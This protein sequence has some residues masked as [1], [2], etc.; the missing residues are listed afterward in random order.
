MHWPSPEQPGAKYSVARGS[1]QGRLRAHNERV[2]LH[3]LRVKGPMARAELA[4][5]S[6][7]TP[8]TIGLIVKRLED[9]EL[10]CQHK[11]VRGRVGQPSIPIGL[12]PDGA[13][14]I[15]IKLGRR[16]TDILL[17]DFSARVLDRCTIEYPYPQVDK[18]PQAIHARLAQMQLTLGAR[19]GRV[20]GV[21]LAAPFMLGGWHR[22][23]GLSAHD[24]DH[25]NRI[26]LQAAIQAGSPW[27]VSFA[28]DT[29][30]ACIAELS[31]GAGQSI[32]N[33]LYLFIDTF[34]GGALVLNGQ[35]HSGIHGNAGAVASLPRATLS[36]TKISNP[37]DA[38]PGQLLQQASLWD[39]EQL[40][41]KQGLDMTAAY[42]ERAL[43]QPFS[44]LT[45]QWIESAADAL[46][47]CVISG[48]AITDV[49]H[50]VIDGSLAAPAL[51]KLLVAT[52]KA[53][54]QYSW[55]GLWRPALLKGQVGSDARALGGALLPLHEQFAPDHEIF[56]K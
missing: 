34:V 51:A 19:S 53:L 7:L 12:N 36:N 37:L 3:T 2:V 44:V 30:A 26:D 5:Q 20:A 23:L 25:W 11:P 52:E 8:Q 38:S 33:F 4:R 1:N 31:F 17:V 56:L 10:I 35:M 39:L 43:A 50:V 14:A 18:L 40:F 46:A 41:S 48:V 13:L 6:G 16:S 55:E 24:A 9:E 29:T 27:P 15:G 21:G 47:H 22:M 49:D 42:D 54:G 32:K 45:S 28:K